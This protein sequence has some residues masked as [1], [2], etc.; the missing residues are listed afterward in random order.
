MDSGSAMQETYLYAVQSMA[1]SSAGA[2]SDSR[3][4]WRPVTG[5]CAKPCCHTETHAVCLLRHCQDSHLS[6]R[7]IR[8]CCKRCAMNMCWTPDQCRLLPNKH[9]MCVCAATT[10]AR[11]RCAFSLQTLLGGAACNQTRRRR[12]HCPWSGGGRLRRHRRL[13]LLL[14]L[15]LRRRVARLLLLGLLRLL[16]LVLDAKLLLVVL[17]VG[18]G[19]LRGTEQ[20]RRHSRRSEADDRPDRLMRKDKSARDQAQQGVT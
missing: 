14:L 11:S 2:V 1:M 18:V 4:W 9:T 13:L 15:P 8:K 17:H 20:H 19:S 12:S 10:G 6:R 16:R 3:T 7:S 5:A